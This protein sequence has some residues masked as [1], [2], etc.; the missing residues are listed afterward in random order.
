LARIRKATDLPIAVGFGIRTP[1]QAAQIAR[2]ADAAV[3]GS[4]IV[5][6]IGDHKGQGVVTKVTELCRALADS[7]HDA[8]GDKVGA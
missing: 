1:V 3:V 6:V 2:F 7:I 8:V 5:S 4:A